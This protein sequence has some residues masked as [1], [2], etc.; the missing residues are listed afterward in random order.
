MRVIACAAS[1]SDETMKSISSSRSRQISRYSTFVVRT[2]VVVDGDS[3]LANIEET[4]FTSSREVQRDH[5]VGLVD[6][7]LPE[8]PAARAVP[9]ERD[10]VVAVGERAQ[11]LRVEIDDD[12]L[13]LVV[14]RLDD[15]RTDL[16]RSDDDDPHGRAEPR[17]LSGN[18]SPARPDV[19]A[20]I[21]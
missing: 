1:S 18:G 4:M 10:D 16:P 5:Q 20:A 9:L 12:D 11:A 3:F 6:P 14:E 15:G 13:V 7:R 21:G 17:W 2:I 19:P 8:R